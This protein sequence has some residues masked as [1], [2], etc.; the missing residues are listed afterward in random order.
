MVTDLV[1]RSYGRRG[2]IGL[3]L[4]RSGRHN[5][6]YFFKARPNMAVASQD[7]V[8]DGQVHPS[9]AATTSLRILKEMAGY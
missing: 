9:A 3:L 8:G 5:N 4:G 6:F 1:A 7:L 2:Q